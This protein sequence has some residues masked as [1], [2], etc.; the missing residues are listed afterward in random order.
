MIFIVKGQDVIYLASETGRIK[1][2]DAIIIVSGLDQL[3]LAKFTFTSVI[4]CC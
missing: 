1:V 2:V 4:R 3:K